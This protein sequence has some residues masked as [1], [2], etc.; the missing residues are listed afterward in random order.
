MAEPALRQKR[1]EP[2]GQ[3]ASAHVHVHAHTLASQGGLRSLLSTTTR[4][5]WRSP[6]LRTASQ[7]GTADEHPTLRVGEIRLSRKLDDYLPRRGPQ[8]PRGAEWPLP[9]VE[10]RL[11]ELGF[12]WNVDFNNIEGAV[13][14]ARAPAPPRP[15]ARRLLAPPRA[16]RVAVPSRAAQNYWVRPAFGFNIQEVIDLFDSWG[17]VVNVFDG[18]E[19]DDK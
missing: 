14:G 17:W 19:E 5:S 3:R 11:K 10:S 16:H 9:G 13:R 7:I 1:A 8:R 12:E 6:V 4:R 2:F 18:L 15:H